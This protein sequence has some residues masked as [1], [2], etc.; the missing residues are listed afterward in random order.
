MKIANILNLKLIKE[1]NTSQTLTSLAASGGNKA[2]GKSFDRIAAG[3]ASPYKNTKHVSEKEKEYPALGKISQRLKDS[4]FTGD[5]IITGPAFTELNR[6]LATTSFKKDEMGNIK[7]PFGDHVVLKQ[8]GQNYFMGIDDQ[9][10]EGKNL[11]A[12]SII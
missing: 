9:S 1:Y 7:L 12:D 3:A 4:A 6:L 11:T 10:E 8:K 5:I 2:Q